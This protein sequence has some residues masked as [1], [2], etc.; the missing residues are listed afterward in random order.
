MSQI[1]R[2]IKPYGI[3]IVFYGILKIGFTLCP[4]GQVLATQEI[5]HFPQLIKNKIIQRIELIC[6]IENFNLFITLL[7]I[8]SMII[9]MDIPVD[10]KID[11]C[12]R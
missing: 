9:Q 4:V 3:F 11:P 12:N 1:R 2:R 7:N 8:A 6:S 5:I 10:E